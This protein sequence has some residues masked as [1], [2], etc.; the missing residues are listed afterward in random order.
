MRKVY[1]NAFGAIQ[2]TAEEAV[3]D[4]QH[5]AKEMSTEVH[6]IES[7]VVKEAKLLHRRHSKILIPNMVDLPSL[8]KTE[9]HGLGEGRTFNTMV[10]ILT[11]AAKSGQ[12][13][14]SNGSI[15]PAPP[16]H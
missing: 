9:A 4:V 7:A 6:S 10:D 12:D 2:H 3:K 14:L 8:T 1:S 11:A 5:L 13:L 15:S 16:D